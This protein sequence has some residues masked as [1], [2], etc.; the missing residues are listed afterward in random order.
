MY[1]PEHRIRAY[2]L[3][4]GSLTYNNL[5]LDMGVYEAP[6]GEVSNAIV[7]GY[8]EAQ[9]L[10]GEINFKEERN[11]FQGVVYKI[12]RLLYEDYLKG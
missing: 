6:S 7:H 12:N 11:N 1:Y 3:Y 2:C 9:Y 5:K 10:S 8:D 4:L